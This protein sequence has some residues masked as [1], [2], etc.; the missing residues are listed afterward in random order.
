MYFEVQNLVKMLGTDD[1]NRNTAMRNAVSAEV[2]NV[3]T[4]RFLARDTR[5]KY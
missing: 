2:I 1:R 3:T 5:V 4:L